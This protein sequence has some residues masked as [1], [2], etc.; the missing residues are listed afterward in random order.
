[1]KKSGWK[2]RKKEGCKDEEGRMEGKVEGERTVRECSAT[3]IDFGLS[4]GSQ[5]ER[6]RKLPETDGLVVERGGF[7]PDIVQGGGGI[8]GG[9][10]P[11]GSVIHY[12]PPALPSPL[13]LLLPASLHHLILRSS[14][15]GSRV[16]PLAPCTSSTP[17]SPSSTPARR[18]YIF[19]ATLPARPS[20]SPQP[21]QVSASYISLFL[22]L[23]FIP[24]VGRINV[25]SV[26]AKARLLCQSLKVPVGCCTKYN[27]NI[28]QPKKL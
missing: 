28:R 26:C 5:R 24:S 25:C 1:M 7:Q 22:V 23:L 20:S 15:G 14:E 4:L 27:S 9:S 2:G 18:T 17:A 16:G 6:E 12:H 3:N 10:V 8:V 19:A 21:E 13:L 11:V